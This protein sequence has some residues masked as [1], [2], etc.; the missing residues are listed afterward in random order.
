MEG[1][2][3][4]VGK[5]LLALVA[6]F[7]VLCLG[8]AIG[9]GVV[10]GVMRIGDILPGGRTG[11]IERPSVDLDREPSV[12]VIEPGAVITE[13]VPDSPADRAGLRPRDVILAV[14][15]QQ[16]GIE[17]DLASL[18]AGYQPRD[19]VTLEV[20][21]LGQEPRKVR[22]ALAE[23]PEKSGVAYLG[24]TYSSSLPFQLPQREGMPFG[25]L[26]EFGLDELPFNLP[27]NGTWQGVVIVRVVEGSPAADAG[28][29][30]GDLITAIDGQHLA[31]PQELIDAIAR[32]RPGDRIAL[33]LLR[34]PTGEEREVEVLL[35]EHPDRDGEAYLGLYLGG[36]FRFNV[37]PGQEGE[38]PVPGLDLDSGS[39]HF[40][41]PL[42]LKEL[43]REFQFHWSPGSNN[44]NSG[45]G[46]SEDSL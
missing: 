16:V 37:V 31:S 1:K 40:N 15:G 45:P 22:V 33:G 7:V 19:R 4:N 2:Q 6:F 9:G 11:V 44:C 28:L 21:S 12:Q 26:E 36:G 46:C 10:Y 3:S 38:E 24:V 17:G 39:F 13:V 34:A 43:D 29:A 42:D 25:H 30:P 14:D 20:Q 41:L 27:H 23:H 32:R 18:I 5:V 35:G 8:M